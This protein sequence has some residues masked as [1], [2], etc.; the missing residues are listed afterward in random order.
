[1]IGTHTS[2][3]V[4]FVGNESAAP[5]IAFGPDDEEGG[6]AM[7]GVESR[8]VEIRPVHGDDG[9]GFQGSGV[10]DGDVV[11]L[12][13]GHMDKGRDG[14]PQI[15]QRV[16][17]DGG[18][19][20]PESRPGKKRQSQVDGRGIQRVQGFVQLDGE[21]FAL[22]EFACRLDERVPEV[23]VD[24][25]IAAFVGVGQG[26]PG[27]EASKSHVVQLLAMGGEAGFDVPQTV[28]SS[29]LGERHGDELVPAGERSY[30]MTPLVLVDDFPEMVMGY[31]LEQLCENRFPRI[32]RRSSP[33]RSG[34]NYMPEAISNRKILKSSLYHYVS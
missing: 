2:G 15:Q 22:I 10:Q 23:L 34:G 3:L 21:A 14:S 28:P 13:R 24:P 1:L 31:L 5:Q 6:Q 11:H 26:G 4:R 18:L 29:E 9:V 30:A 20:F 16:H 32:H 19:G 12:A 7:D 27:D 17:L 33:G 25:K 8:K